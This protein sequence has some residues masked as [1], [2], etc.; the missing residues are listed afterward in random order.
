MAV[1]NIKFSPGFISALK[2]IKSKYEEE[3]T[4]ATKMGMQDM[5]QEQADIWLQQQFYSLFGKYGLPDKHFGYAE[6]VSA[7]KLVEEG[8]V[9]SASLVK[10][11]EGETVIES[12][13]ALPGLQ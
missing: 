12:V 13:V 6:L 2:N 3:L 10:E 9:G 11:V 1:I 7:I 8:L 5:A 4:F